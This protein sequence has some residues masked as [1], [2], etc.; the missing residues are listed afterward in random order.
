MPLTLPELRR[1]ISRLTRPRPS[2]N[3]ILHSDDYS[4][5]PASATTNDAAIHHPK[6]TKHQFA[7][8]L[9]Q[10]IAKAIVGPDTWDKIR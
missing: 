7:R 1:L 8:K 3:H 10:S 6:P 5:K 4:A 9:V 2:I